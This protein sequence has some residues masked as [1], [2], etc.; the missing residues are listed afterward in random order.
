MVGIDDVVLVEWKRHHDMRGFFEETFKPDY[1]GQVF[2]QDNRSQSAR[3]VVRGLHYQ[4]G[5]GKLM[6]VG[7]GAA[8]L[9]AV[10]LRAQSETFG[11]HVGLVLTEQDPCAVWAPDG[12]ARG[13]QAL[14]DC[15]EICYKCTCKYDPTTEGAVRWDSVGIQWP[16]EPTIISP[17]DRTAQTFDEY[18]RKP[19]F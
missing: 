9:V 2:V 7:R 17:K 6:R 19:R 12:F 4:P 11:E 15:T 16:I 14:D 8:Y 18:R 1:L 10:D 13:F 5:M 3:G